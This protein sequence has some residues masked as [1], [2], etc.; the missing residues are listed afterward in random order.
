MPKQED[1]IG[2]R[3]VYRDLV[4]SRSLTTIFRPNDQ[5]YEELYGTGSLVEGIIIQQPGSASLSIKPIFTEDTIRLKVKSIKR[6]ALKNLKQEDFLGSSPDVQD[7]TGLIYHLGMIYDKPAN[8]YVPNTKIIKIEL[9][10][11]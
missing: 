11:V 8:S 9:E 10:Y 2:F 7:T 3:M 4:L 1:A 6:I 5:K